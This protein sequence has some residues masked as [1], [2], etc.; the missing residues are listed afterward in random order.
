MKI[1]NYELDINA[2]DTSAKEYADHIQEELE[3]AFEVFDTHSMNHTG[4]ILQGKKEM[5]LHVISFIKITKPL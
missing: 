3:K 1:Q 2:P 5:L 4:L